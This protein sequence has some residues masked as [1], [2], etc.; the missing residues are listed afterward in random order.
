[1]SKSKKDSK[2]IDQLSEMMKTLEKE[3][4][5]LVQGPVLT[6]HDL[7]TPY[8]H[9]FTSAAKRGMANKVLELKPKRKLKFLT[10][11][12]SEVEDEVVFFTAIAVGPEKIVKA[13]RI[14]TDLINGYAAKGHITGCLSPLS[15]ICLFSENYQLERYAVYCFPSMTAEGAKLAHESKSIYI[16]QE[17]MVGPEVT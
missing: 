17:G 2:L 9:M 6:T 15:Y 11:L 16:T 3:S 14:I 1:M 5:T 10:G 13:A 8:S 4:Q 12:N 7:A